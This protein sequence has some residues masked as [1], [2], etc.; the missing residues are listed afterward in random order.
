MHSGRI[1]FSKI[2]SIFNM[3]FNQNFLLSQVRFL[4]ISFKIVAWLWIKCY[5]TSPWGWKNAE[6]QYLEGCAYCWMLPPWE[7]SLSDEKRSVTCGLNAFSAQ[8]TRCVAQQ[9]K[10]STRRTRF[11]VQAPSDLQHSNERT[12]KNYIL[13][14]RQVT[15]M[16]QMHSVQLWRQNLY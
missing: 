3:G 13:T 5:S 10:N 2:S 6:I 7:R 14:N 1:S 12:L 16:V 8:D 11:R 9:P 4:I 15:S